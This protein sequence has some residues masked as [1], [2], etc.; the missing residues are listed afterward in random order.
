MAFNKRYDR[1]HLPMLWA[2]IAIWLLSVIISWL[3]NGNSTE[4]TQTTLMEITKSAYQHMPLFTIALLCVCGPVLEEF[5]FR[6]WGIGKEWAFILTVIL[7]TLF[8]TGELGWWSLLLIVPFIIAYILV[9]DRFRKQWALTLISTTAFTLCHI[10]GFGAFSVDMVLGLANIFGFALV[11]CWLAINIGFVWA[12]LLHVLNNTCAILLPLLLTPEPTITTHTTPDGH[13]VETRIVQRSLADKDQTTPT[14]TSCRW[15]TYHGEP[16]EIAV[17]LINNLRADQGL[18]TN[19]PYYRSLSRNTSLEERITY[20]IQWDEQE[21]MNAQRELEYFL[22]DYESHSGSPLTFDT[23]MVELME[24]ELQEQPEDNGNN[25][26][27]NINDTSRVD[28]YELEIAQNQMK[29][30]H[31]TLI[32]Y[33]DT[34]TR[35]YG[36]KTGEVNPLLE[37]SG[38]TE[39]QSLYSY[40]QKI[41]Y[42]P[43]GIYVQLISVK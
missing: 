21:P 29:K 24:I 36:I 33:G 3:L 31:Y 15:A 26:P 41:T 10:S 43:T 8:C 4:S 9:K 14:D 42:T 13:T 38:I 2:G 11:L 1:R 20:T 18:A 6:L 35:Y 17:A 16:S 19:E 34:A 39:L 7:M 12:C 28:T 40:Y 37:S 30:G 23:T 22:K 27:Y 32:S 5:S 25:T